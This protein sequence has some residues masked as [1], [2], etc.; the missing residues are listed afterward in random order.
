MHY[1]TLKEYKEIIKHRKNADAAKDNERHWLMEAVAY[2]WYA[3]IDKIT[4]E[5]LRKKYIKKNAE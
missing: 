3:T 5:Q 2:S 4:H 1:T